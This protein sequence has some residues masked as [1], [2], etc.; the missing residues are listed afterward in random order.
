MQFN[1]V[2]FFVFFAIS[3]FLYYGVP[4]KSRKWLLLVINLFFYSCFSISA[5]IGL[6]TIALI[7]WLGEV[8]LSRVQKKIWLLIFVALTLFPLIGLKYFDLLPGYILPVGISFFTL[9]AIK[10]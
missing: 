5:V 6:V 4:N 7:S 2:A 9:Q 10:K 3:L 8:L 1:S